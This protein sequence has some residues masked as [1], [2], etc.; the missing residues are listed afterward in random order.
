MKKMFTA[1][2]NWF[3]TEAK[4]RDA[5]VLP[6]RLFIGLGW[7]RSS[8]EKVIQPE[9]HSG[10]ALNQFFAEQIAAGD[11][12]F[13]FYQSLMEGTF[14]LYAPF[15]SKLIMVGEFYCG[16]ALLLGLLTRTALTAGIFMN[17]NFILAGVVSPSAFYIVIQGILLP[18]AVGRV[19]GVDAIFPSSQDLFGS[20]LP[21]TR[22][23]A[24]IKSILCVGGSLLTLFLATQIFPYISSFNPAHSVEDPAML[25]LILCGLQTLLLLILGVR[26]VQAEEVPP[27]T[28]AS[29]NF[30]PL[31]NP[32]PELIGS[33]L[34]TQSIEHGTVGHRNHRSSQPLAENNHGLFSAERR[35]AESPSF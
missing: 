29:Q 23:H 20:V 4:K 28:L 22:S 16:I 25:L 27:Q 2:Q 31:Q 30:K 32:I 34:Y 19:F 7:V 17:L 12:A 26:T 24:R 1:F 6:L 33:G 8:V 11:V 9:W 5:I 15:L 14:S 21:P 18:S 10:V 35:I 13:P 3:Y